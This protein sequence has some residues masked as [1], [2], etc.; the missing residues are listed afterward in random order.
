MVSTILPCKRGLEDDSRSAVEAALELG[1]E[2]ACT[3]HREAEMEKIQEFLSAAWK[4][5]RGGSLYV[6]GGPGTGKTLHVSR[7]MKAVVEDDDDSEETRSQ[8]K[9]NKKKKSLKSSRFGFESATLKGTAFSSAKDFLKAIVLNFAGSALTKKYAFETM[10]AKD[11]LEVFREEILVKKKKSLV[12]VVDEIDSLIGV[13]FDA[14]SQLFHLANDLTSGFCL[15]GIAN[16][17]DLPQRALDASP[18]RVVVFEPYDFKTLMAILEDRIK[19]P[20]LFDAQAI[21]LCARK[22]AA[23][24][25][26]AR[27]TLDIALRA[28]RTSEGVVSLRTVMNAF[29]D[30]TASPLVAAIAGLAPKA[31]LVIKAA[32]N[33]AKTTNSFSKRDLLR[34]YK[35]SLPAIARDGTDDDA[36][37]LLESMGILIAADSSNNKKATTTKKKKLGTSRSN[38]ASYQGTI[39]SLACDINDIQAALEGDN[40]NDKK[41]RILPAAAAVTI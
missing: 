15:V 37:N 31:K 7:A 24:T 34:A 16:A 30:A 35:A 6:C 23:G 1:F 10:A 20:N 8:K 25:G 32:V 27:K 13:A 12:V 9:K 29:K 22:V 18:T 3:R 21:E 28:L 39:L 5:K 17:I 4:E 19:G 38:G 36:V 14:V 11:L 41:K 26:D 2:P 40:D 33:L